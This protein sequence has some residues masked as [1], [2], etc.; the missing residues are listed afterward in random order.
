MAQRPISPEIW[1]QIREVFDAAIER[2]AAERERLVQAAVAKNPAIREELDRML[3]WHSRVGPFLEPAE[4]PVTQTVQPQH[5]A[6]GTSPNEIPTSYDPESDRP[7]GVSPLGIH[8]EGY[9]IIRELARG[10][11]GIV[12]EAQQLKLKRK[13]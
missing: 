9:H 7:A 3:A 5:G 12:Y 13:V 6:A 10:G 4:S 1:A 2:P 8:I 11:M